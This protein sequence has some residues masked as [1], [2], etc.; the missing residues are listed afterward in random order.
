M[1][2]Y[3]DCVVPFEGA[4]GG[5]RDRD[6]YFRFQPLTSLDQPIP[7]EPEFWWFPVHYRYCNDD[8]FANIVQPWSEFKVPDFAI[9]TRLDAHCCPPIETSSQIQYASVNSMQRWVYRIL[10]LEYHQI[11]PSTPICVSH[12]INVQ[13]FVQHWTLDGK[14]AVHLSS[15][16]KLIVPVQ[17]DDLIITCVYVR[18]IMC[19]IVWLELCYSRGEIIS[20]DQAIKQLDAHID[21]Y[22]Q[23]GKLGSNVG[24][25]ASSRRGSRASSDR[26]LRGHRKTLH[27]ANATKKQNTIKE[28]DEPLPHGAMVTVT[29]LNNE[30][31]TLPDH[32]KK[33]GEGSGEMTQKT[34]RWSWS[35]PF[36]Q[37]MR[38]IRRNSVK[39][40]HSLKP[41]KLGNETDLTL[42][43]PPTS[44]MPSRCTT[45]DGCKEPSVLADAARIELDTA[46]IQ[47]AQLSMAS[48]PPND[49]NTYDHGLNTGNVGY[50]MEDAASTRAL[51]SRRTS[52]NIQSARLSKASNPPYAQN[53]YDHVL[54]TCNIGYEMEDAAS[55]RALISPNDQNN[56]HHVLNTGNVGYEM[57]DAASTRAMKSRRASSNPDDQNPTPIEE[58]ESEGGDEEWSDLPDDPQV[59]AMTPQSWLGL[60]SEEIEAQEPC[61]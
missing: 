11:T 34:N 48:N 61:E 40:Q 7:E 16:E 58:P 3:A 27:R 55:T 4:T 12:P 52:S 33:Q 24:S 53:N 6:E 13:H 18:E 2:D 42:P 41:K 60:P 51:K 56:Y 50:E 49:H 26:Q 37:R 10:T 43:Y 5:L 31:L 46:T 57:E 21:Q 39:S 44:N 28:V 9:Q 20:I 45:P 17:E 35:R 59:L 25:R 29:D 8:S 23:F 30:I 32:P 14:Q 47:I 36:F 54:G 38:V 19:D 22:L 1:S 15:R